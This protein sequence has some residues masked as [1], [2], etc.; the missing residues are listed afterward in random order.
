MADEVTGTPLSSAEQIA[1]NYKKYADLYNQKKD[2]QIN[3]DT[4]L[5]L[6]VAEMTNQD[7]LEPTSNTEFISQMAQFSSL[8]SMENASYYSNATYASSLVGKTVTVASYTGADYKTETGVVQSI[9]LSDKTFNIKVNGNSY[10]LSAIQSV[11]PDT[12]EEVSSSADKTYAATLVGMYVTVQAK[13]ANDKVVVDEGIVDSFEVKDGQ[14]GL[15][16][17]GVSY[18]LDDVVKVRYGTVTGTEGTDGAGT[19]DGTDAADETDK[20]D[21][22]DAADEADTTG[23]V[24]TELAPDNTNGSSLNDIADVTEDYADVEDIELDVNEYVRS[25][26]EGIEDES[27]VD[28]V[29]EQLLEMVK[30]GEI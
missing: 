6:L 16:I 15:I 25:L 28:G 13:D 2:N 22:T 30:N 8:Q 5:N 12:T 9:E 20:A 27:D 3:V 17:G 29:F 24:T 18:K 19:A 23:E 4:F 10:K 26:I 14:V 7:P 11:K 1:S 21:E